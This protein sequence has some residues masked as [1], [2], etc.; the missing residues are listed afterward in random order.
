MQTNALQIFLS[1]MSAHK[2][3]TKEA[4]KI[5]NVPYLTDFNINDQWEKLS[6]FLKML[7]FKRLV[8]MGPDETPVRVPKALN[9]FSL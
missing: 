7:F 6:M 2:P 1:D 8:V 5:K 4:W 3:Y 9:L